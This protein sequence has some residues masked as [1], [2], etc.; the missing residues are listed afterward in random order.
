MF[1]V[2][3]NIP[4]INYRSE[5]VLKLPAQL[6]TIVD[7][8]AM[9]AVCDICPTKVKYHTEFDVIKTICGVTYV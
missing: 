1:V 7:T 9:S 3:R 4:L 6:L 8:N 2:K 5:Y